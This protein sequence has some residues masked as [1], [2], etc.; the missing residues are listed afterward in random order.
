[1]KL[2]IVATRDIVANLYSAPQFVPTIGQAVRSFG[3]ACQNTQDPNNILAKHPRDFELWHLGE[4]DDEAG[5]FDP[6]NKKQ[7]A[8]GANY[9]KVSSTGGHPAP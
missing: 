6:S 7:I 9:V 1:M 2:Q 4:Y 8:V 3:D 5:T